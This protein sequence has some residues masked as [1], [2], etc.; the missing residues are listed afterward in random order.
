MPNFRAQFIYCFTAGKVCFTTQR[1]KLITL[2]G[3][4]DHSLVMMI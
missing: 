4:L 1:V 3:R 2:C